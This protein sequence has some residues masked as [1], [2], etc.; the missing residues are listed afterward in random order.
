M[1]KTILVVDDEKN[2]LRSLEGILSD[3]GFEVLSAESGVDALEMIR[4]STP[5]LVLLDIWMEGLDGIETLE[6]IKKGYPNLQVIMMS[7]H[8]NIE[9][10]VKATKIGA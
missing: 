5:D 2:I 9:T 3:E 6:E 1:A 8:G 4:E 7:G 10:A